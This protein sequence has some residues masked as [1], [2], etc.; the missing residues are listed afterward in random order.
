MPDAKQG[1]SDVL[2][3]I[4]TLHQAARGT[5][6]R[7]TRAYELLLPMQGLEI[8]RESCPPK[9]P[10]CFLSA[11][12]CFCMGLDENGKRSLYCKRTARRRYFSLIMI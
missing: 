3:P 9:L 4:L 2:Q 5:F 1:I 11:H 6:G 12:L 8:V 10:P 7:M